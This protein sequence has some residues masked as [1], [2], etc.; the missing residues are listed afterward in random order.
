MKKLELKHLAAYLPYGLKIHTGSEIIELGGFHNE[1]WLNIFG[2]EI[3]CEGEIKPIL[4]PISD[5][6]KPSLEC[7]LIPIVELAKIAYPK[8]LK[9]IHQVGN[10]CF[11]DSREKY[12]FGYAN[13][14][15][16]FICT[17]IPENRN[18]FVNNQL[19]LFEYLF[20]HHFDVYGLIEA[21]LAIDINSI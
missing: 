4:H 17:Y 1:N 18:C 12:V 9:G 8:I 14:A 21:G 15:S 5:L 19:D 10:I 20:A 16:S 6:T 3:Y 7:G 11:I 13:E 2:N